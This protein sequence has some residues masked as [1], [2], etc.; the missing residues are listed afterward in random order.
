MI[1]QRDEELFNEI[2]RTWSSEWSV[3][4]IKVEVNRQGRKK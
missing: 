4:K 1:K 2:I 3:K